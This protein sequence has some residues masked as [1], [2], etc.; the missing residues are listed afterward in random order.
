MAIQ[1]NQN[2]PEIKETTIQLV[3]ILHL[4]DVVPEGSVELDV[5]QEPGVVPGAEAGLDYA[6]PMAKDVELRQRHIRRHLN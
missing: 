1:N 6:L 5:G 4:D 2:A 3:I